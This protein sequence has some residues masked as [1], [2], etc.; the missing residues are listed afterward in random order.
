MHVSADDL[1]AA[2]RA[3]GMRVTRPRRALCAVLADAHAAHLTAAELRRRAEEVLGASIDLSTVYRTLDALDQAGL[4]HHVHLGH[5]P[6]VAHLSGEDDHHHLVCEVCGATVD[7]PRHEV[8]ELMATLERRYGYQVD[9]LHF[10]LVGRCPRHAG[11][12]PSS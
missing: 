3:A 7:V 4:L 12:G 2:L 1:V 11:D 6:S 9:S 5:G 10:A 8:A